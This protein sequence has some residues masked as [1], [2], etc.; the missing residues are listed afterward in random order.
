LAASL[1]MLKSGVAQAEIY[2]DDIKQNMCW[3]TRER[4]VTADNIT[5][6]ANVS[7]DFG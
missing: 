1:M 6:F 7:G 4:V 5:T 3:R 2:F